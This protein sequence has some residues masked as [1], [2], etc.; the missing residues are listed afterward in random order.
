MPKEEDFTKQSLDQTGS[1]NLDLAKHSGGACLAYTDRLSE[2][3]AAKRLFAD[4]QDAER[5]PGKKIKRGTDGNLPHSFLFTKG[6]RLLALANKS[7]GNLGKGGHGRV[8]LAEDEEGNLYALKIMPVPKPSYHGI[9]GEMS[10]AYDQGASQEATATYRTSGDRWK[11]YLPLIYLGR[12]SSC[13][14]SKCYRRGLS[15]PHN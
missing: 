14:I 9:E 2:W 8:K 10:K 11:A 1:E 13:L 15:L 6:N 5:T 12:P 7:D 4:F 3:R